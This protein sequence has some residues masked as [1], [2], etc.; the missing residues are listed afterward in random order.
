MCEEITFCA[1]GDSFM[2]RGISPNDPD[3]NELSGLIQSANVRFSNLEITVEG[4][5]S[6]PGAV[7]G[8][9]WAKTSSKVL[10][11]LDTYGFNMLAWAN[12]HTLDYAFGGLAST[13]SFLNEEGYVHAGA[14]ENLAAASEPR[15][16]ETDK[17]RVALIS[18]TSTFPESWIAGDQRPDMTG[19][20]GINPLRFE[21]VHK[22]SPERMKHL[23]EI[24]NVTGINKENDLEAAGGF[25]EIK[26]DLFYFGGH[27][28]KESKEEGRDTVPLPE[29]M[30]RILQAIKNA[31]YA[32]DYV[33]VS[34]H[35]HEMKW[36]KLNEPAEFLETFSKQCVDA[37]A[38]AI[39]GHGPHVLRGIE[40]YKGCP[41][42]YS[43]GNFIFQN[44]TVSHLPA[45]FYTKYGLGHEEVIS[46]ALSIRSQD[47]TRGF[48]IDSDIWES[49]LPIWKMK[50]GKL[51]HLE[52]HPV[53]LGQSLPRYRRGSPKLSK[54]ISIIENMRKLSEE[55]GTEIEI[56]DHKGIIKL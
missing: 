2:T 17:G 29:D 35:S 51:T 49:V 8:G 26:D 9:T 1:T 44:E 55:F 23:K 12:N 15:Y 13:E 16:L 45:D 4:E 5:N 37:G 6:I 18:V 56:K 46:T 10:K 14:G 41:I 11:S 7:S 47:D 50:H 38:N 52:L 48:A 31:S 25:R 20:P 53:T 36:D 39:I 3:A 43:L 27:Y 32:A 24:A 40:I 30:E 42:F 22:I 33:L 28:F 19:R 54:D 21:T 34:V